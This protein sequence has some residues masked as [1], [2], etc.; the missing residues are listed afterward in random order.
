M[1]MGLYCSKVT[2]T[3][4]TN[5]Q[6]T[7]HILTLKGP[8]GT[9]RCQGAKEKQQQGRETAGSQGG[10]TFRQRCCSLSAPRQV[11]GR[12]IGRQNISLFQPALWFGADVFE[13]TLDI[14]SVTERHTCRNGAFWKE[15]SENLVSFHLFCES[16][17]M[18]QCVRITDETFS[19]LGIFLSWLRCSTLLALGV[20][21]FLP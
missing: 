9:A 1:D 18:T 10:R 8:A 14:K 5:T 13:I 15:N 2:H 7:H 4:N 6:C 17:S 20:V 21:P 16:K 19:L 11:V 12:L 3:H